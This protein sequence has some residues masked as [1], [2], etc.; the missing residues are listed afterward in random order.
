MS[1]TKAPTLFGREMPSRPYF[2]TR[3]WF[4]KIG[5]AE[6]RVVELFGNAG[7]RAHWPDGN[8]C[9]RSTP[10]AAANDAERYLRRLHR[11]LGKVVGHEG[12]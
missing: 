2:V 12:E 10:Q 5:P 11:A 6:V 9:D 3:A 4:T 8:G 7:Y 1:T